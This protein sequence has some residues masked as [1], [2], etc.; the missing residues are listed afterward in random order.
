[1]SAVF[2]EFK[3]DF[4]P[5]ENV[6]VFFEDGDNFT[7]LIREKAKFPMIRQVH[8]GVIVAKVVDP[9]AYTLLRGPDG[10]VQ[11]PA[12]SRYFV[13]LPD[14]PDKEALVDD[15]HIRRDKKVFTK[16][17]LRQFLKSSLQRESWIGAPWLVKEHL[18]ITHRLP[19][20]I[21]PHL[22]QDAK[23]LAN[24]VCM[25]SPCMTSLDGWLLTFASNKCFT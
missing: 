16:Q 25:L 4:F 13:R 3:K 24:K 21:P 22:M 19:M 8:S 17:N 12:F 18:A 15:K 20:E 7:G 2:D 23:L 5:G 1:M 10:A 9:F 6:H 14:M 11:R